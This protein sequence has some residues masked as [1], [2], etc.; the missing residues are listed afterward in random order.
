MKCQI[1]FSRK[2]KENI[3]KDGLL[4]F[5]PI[6]QSAIAKNNYQKLCNI[7]YAVKL[8]LFHMLLNKLNLMQ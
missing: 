2:K 5:L 8:L 6:M 3:S 4:K 7:V 1:L